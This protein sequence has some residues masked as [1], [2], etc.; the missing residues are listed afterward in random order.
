[1]VQRAETADGAKADQDPTRPPPRPGP[2]RP[3]LYRSAE[4]L[5]LP[6][7]TLV[8]SVV[9]GHCLHPVT[10]PGLGPHTEDWF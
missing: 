2:W 10:G 1:M 3:W 9:T 7:A 5:R 6:S 4:T 8:A